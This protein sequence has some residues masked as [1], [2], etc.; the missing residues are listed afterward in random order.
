MALAGTRASK[1]KR[2][3]HARIVRGC[4]KTRGLNSLGDAKLI[5]RLPRPEA[6]QVSSDV[7]VTFEMPNSNLEIGGAT[8]G[9]IPIASSS[10]SCSVACERPTQH[11]RSALLL[12]AQ[13]R[14]GYASESCNVI[15]WV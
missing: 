14:G 12:Q 15:R 13:A 6:T 4:A 11:L 3:Q 10:S 5:S 1:R 9:A 8:R 7:G 2:P